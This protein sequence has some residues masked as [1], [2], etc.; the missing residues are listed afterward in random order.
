MLPTVDVFQSTVVVEPNCVVVSSVGAVVDTALPV[1]VSHSPVE[2]MSTVVDTAS[3]VVA[4]GVVDTVV[5]RTSATSEPADSSASIT[6]V[7]D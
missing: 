6:N 5:V 4:G 1:V 7:N 3:L 2:G